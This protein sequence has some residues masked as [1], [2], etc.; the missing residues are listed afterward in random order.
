MKKAIGFFL[1]FTVFHLQAQEPVT[2]KEEKIVSQN[3]LSIQIQYKKGYSVVDSL[4][5]DNKATLDR[6]VTLINS[7]DTDPLTS[8][9][10]ISIKGNASPEGFVDKNRSLVGKRASLLRQYLLD[11]TTL[12]DTAIKVV[13]S[14]IDWEALRNMIA[15]TDQ[16][17]RDM[18]I[19]IIDHTPLFI[20]DKNRRI[21]DGKKKRLGMLYGGRAWKYMENNFFPDLRNAAVRIE[22]IQENVPSDNGIPKNVVEQLSTEENVVEGTTEFTMQVEETL[23]ESAQQVPTVPMSKDKKSTVLLK[24]NML[25][26]IVAVP[27]IGIEIP[28]GKNWSVETNWM[29]AWWNS[30]AKNIS[31]RTY[32]GNLEIRKWFSPHKEFKS[33]MCGHHVGIYGQMVTYDFGWGSTG[34]LS[35]KWS[36]GVG[37]SYGYSLPVGNHFNIDFSLGL[38]YLQGS[39]MKYH[40]QDN[41]YVW[42]S[43][44]IRKWFGP[45][46]MEISLVWFIGGRKEKG[47]AK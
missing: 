22:Y 46:K 1:L 40:P 3:S 41:C 9:K 38:G 28:I 42:D 35:D 29:Y 5:R 16:P 11:R 36:W 4:F 33:F 31:W 37:L 43:T 25:Y 15:V 17:W 20:Y 47:G 14:D 6:L 18:A 19:E 44:H 34:Y 2:Q 30:N 10:S 24:T 12:P 21:I 45:T 32:G 39:Y 27:N 8:I 23:A 13:A 7:L 26:D